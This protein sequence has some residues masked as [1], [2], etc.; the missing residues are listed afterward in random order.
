MLRNLHKES[1]NGKLIGLKPPIEAYT[2]NKNIAEDGILELKRAYQRTMI[3]TNTR[4]C[5]W[6]LCLVHTALIR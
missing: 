2:P 5:L 1:S 4:A 3:A 6:D